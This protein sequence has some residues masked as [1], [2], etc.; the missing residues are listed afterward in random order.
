MRKSLLF[1]LTIFI[2]GASIA[3][4]PIHKKETIELGGIKQYITIQ[5]ASDTSPVLLFLHGGPGNS[6]MP[7]ADKFTGELQKHFIVVHWDQRSSGRTA[8]LNASTVPVSVTLI[9]SDALELVNYLRKRF[10]QDKI[11]VMGHS[12][13]GFLALDLASKHPELL[14]ACFAL[15]P[16]VNQ[17]ESERLSLAWMKEKAAGDAI[18]LAELEQ[19]QVPF[20]NCKQLYLHRK[21]L[22]HFSGSRF[23]S[24]GFVEAWAK[25]WLPVFNEA[26]HVNFITSVPEIRCPIYF[27]IGSSDRQTHYSLTEYFYKN[28][29]AEKKDLFWFTN[30]GHNLNLT[31]PIKL[32]ETVISILN[33][34]H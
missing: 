19:V 11:Y 12:W 20:Q 4:G 26:S 13:G 14:K 28:L 7:Y 5:G 10:S 1:I 24:Q 34:N 21:W 15:A 25:T 16:M 18:A 31:E 8:R 9:E 23:P 6:V 30:S 29:K 2:G 32:Q 33:S 27:F 17:L 22:A 3:S